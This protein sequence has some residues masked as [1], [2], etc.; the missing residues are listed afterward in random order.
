MANI[1]TYIK[2]K[3]GQ[4]K[5]TYP[6]PRLEKILDKTYGVVTYQEDVLLIAIELAGYNWDT[7]D[8]FRKAI[9]KKIPEEMAKQEKIFIE[10]CQKHGGLTLQKAEELWQLFDPFK[11]YAFNKAHAASYAKVA[12]QTAYMKANYPA[13]FMAAV[14]TADSGEVEKIA[15]TIGECVRMNLPVLPPDV[16]ESLG[17]FAVVSIKEK[18]KETEGIRFG[19]YTIKNLGKEIAN[20]IIEER[21]ANGRY[22]SFSDFLDCVQHKNLNKKSLES[23]IKSGA[24]DAFGERNKLIFN[25]EDALAYNKESGKAKKNQ[26]SLFALMADNASLPELRFKE[27]EPA[28]QHDKLLWEKELLGLYV[29]GHPLDKFK[30]KLEKIKTKIGDIKNLPDNMPIVT[31]GMIETA[32]KINT[33]KGDPMIFMKL[34]DYADSIENVIFPKIFEKYASIIREGNCIAVKGRHS[35]RNGEHS[36]L[37]EEIKEMT[38]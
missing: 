27:T 10:G 12:Y 15:E 33:K 25:M 36:I 29:S 22:K 19:L 21:L 20:A 38:V 28:S 7:V 32:K 34:S 24:M 8:K 17:D 14:L 1:P 16:N 4:E 3:H 31:A 26:S 2:R 5:I 18:G 13:E 9:G 30:D 37:V 6:D 23:L 11:S 35:I